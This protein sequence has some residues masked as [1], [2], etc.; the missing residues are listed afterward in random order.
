MLPGGPGP[1]L[2]VAGTEPTLL[3]LS[4]AGGRLVLLDVDR[5]VEPAENLC[6]PRLYR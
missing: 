2:W 6:P 5:H 1:Q 4:S 3:G